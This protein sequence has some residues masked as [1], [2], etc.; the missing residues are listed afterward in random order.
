MDA[1]GGLAAGEATEPAV[2]VPWY[3][4]WAA[5]GGPR[6]CVTGV[7]VLAWAWGCPATPCHAYQ[8]PS[9]WTQASLSGEGL[10]A[11]HFAATASVATA[12]AAAPV[13][14]AP[15]TAS[16]AVA[17]S[18][19]DSETEDWEQYSRQLGS[20]GEHLRP[21]GSVTPVVGRGLRCIC[22]ALTGIPRARTCSCF[23]TV[24]AA[25]AVASVAAA[26]ATA[27]VAA[28]PDTASVAAAPDTASVAPAASV[29]EEGCAGERTGLAGPRAQTGPQPHP[30]RQISDAAPLALLTV[31]GGDSCMMEIYE[32][33]GTH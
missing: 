21:V 28:A 32:L 18:G 5:L 7:R 3:D 23:C 24:S 33:E 27:S 11:H 14:A 4:W 10:P 1:P 20:D 8:P 12:P 17:R 31:C 13:A 15:A 16:V 9:G 6:A 22:G 25:P 29:A 19:A 26:P 30:L 2:G